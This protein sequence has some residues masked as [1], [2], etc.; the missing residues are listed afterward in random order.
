MRNLVSVFADE[1]SRGMALTLVPDMGVKLSASTAEGGA[2]SQNVAG[3]CHAG[4][5]MT[6]GLNADYVLDCLRTMA[7]A[8]PIGAGKGAGKGKG[9]NAAAND[10]VRISLHDE[11][12]AALFEPVDGNGYDHKTVIMPMRI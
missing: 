1:R 2:V 6:I 3:E 11:R 12:S 5:G 9:K 8:P 10:D 4:S 7:M